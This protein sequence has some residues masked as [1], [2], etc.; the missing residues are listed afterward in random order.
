VAAQATPL[1]A[2]NTAIDD[3]TFAYVM[4]LRNF[5]SM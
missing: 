1:I 2:M 3:M 4:R 5:W